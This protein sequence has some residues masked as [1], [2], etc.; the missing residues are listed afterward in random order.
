[1][2]DKSAEIFAFPSGSE[3]DADA[4]LELARTKWDISEVLIVGIDTSDR[5][6]WGSSSPN[7]KDILYLLEKAKADLDL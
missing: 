6:I 3:I 2:D 1:M 5:F 7:K 4:L